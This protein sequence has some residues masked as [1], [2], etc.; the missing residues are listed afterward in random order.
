MN[1]ENFQPHTPNHA[2]HNALIMLEW[3][4]ELSDQTLAAIHSLSPKLREFFPKVET[5]KLMTINVGHHGSSP[6]LEGIGAVTFQRVNSFGTPAKQLVVSRQNCIFQVTDY[7]SWDVFLAD[8][9]RNLD[10]VIPTILSNRPINNV[11]L[12]YTNLFTWKEEPG[13]LDLRCVFQEDSKFI[14]ANSLSLRKI[15]HSHYGYV[16]DSKDDLEHDRLHNININVNDDAGERVV[17]IVMSHRATLKN[18]LRRSTPDYMGVISKVETSL[19]SANKDILKLLL[20]EP[21]ASKI[22]LINI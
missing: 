8:A 9:I 19:H 2:V 5:A 13:S 18:P 6:A 11:T 15:W 1:I 3:Q 16:E 12:Q 21:V 10:L 20:T 14:P 22:G 7:I 4:G 17:Q